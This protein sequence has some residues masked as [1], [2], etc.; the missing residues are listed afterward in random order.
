MIRLV[1]ERG[2]TGER[3]KFGKKGSWANTELVP[4]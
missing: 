2:V 4:G 3:G 1:M